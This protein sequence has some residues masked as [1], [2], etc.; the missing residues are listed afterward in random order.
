MSD[1]HVIL[2]LVCINLF[3]SRSAVWLI[4][5]WCGQPVLGASGRRY[6][7]AWV[8]RSVPLSWEQ[9]QLFSIVFVMRCFGLIWIQIVLGSKKRP[10]VL[11]YLVCCWM[12]IIIII[13][14]FAL[15]TLCRR[16]EVGQG[17]LKEEQ[18]FQMHFRTN[19]ELTAWPYRKWWL[20][21]V[22]RL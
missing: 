10:V 7:S 13:I 17:K 22:W 2:W 14:I 11:K 3:E 4:H 6:V 8:C 18:H 12:T 20:V 9:L 1:V 19:R 21:Q 5:T 16:I 15:V